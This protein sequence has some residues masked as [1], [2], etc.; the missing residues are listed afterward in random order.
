MITHVFCNCKNQM[1]EE[2]KRGV[3]ICLNCNNDILVSEDMPDYSECNDL[4]PDDSGAYEDSRE[5]D[6][7]RMGGDRP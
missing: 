1:P 3:V 6:Q 2:I 5:V 4:V 7:V